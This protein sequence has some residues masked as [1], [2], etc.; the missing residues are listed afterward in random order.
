MFNSNLRKEMVE[1]YTNTVKRYR[2]TAKKL[3]INSKKLYEVRLEVIESIK[4]VEE[5]IN[6]LANTPKEFEK[7]INEINI[8]FSN[9]NYKLE[10]IKKAEKEVQ[11]SSAGTGVGV[12]LT[13]F[14]LAVA[15]LGPTAAMGYATTFGIASTGTAISSLYGAAGTNAALA[16]IGGGALSVGGGG[17][18]AG[19][20]F[21]SLAG[22]I[23]WSLAGGMLL[24]SA[25]TAYFSNSKNKEIAEEAIRE[26]MKIEEIIRKFLK[27]YEEIESLIEITKNQIQGIREINRTLKKNNYN[28]FSLEEKYCVG[29][30]VNSTLTLAQLINKEVKIDE[31]E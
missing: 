21:L 7:I 17:I 30:L 15:T 3:E 28:D 4:I 27:M 31:E 19:T 13:G 18:A 26:R 20:T 11:L 14:G 23:G 22:P 2:K 29:I 9:F 12:T 16:Y 1:N 8:E 6:N 25:G 5:Y 10:E 24:I